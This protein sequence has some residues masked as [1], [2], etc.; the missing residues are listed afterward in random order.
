MAV[1]NPRAYEFATDPQ[2]VAAFRAWLDQQIE[3]DIFTIEQTETWQA[4]LGSMAIGP[5]T[6]HYVGSA[7]K[8]GL[9]NAYLA[10][11]VLAD[12]TQAQAEFIRSM[13]TSPERMSKV[14]LLGTRAF[15]GMKGIT[16]TMA[17]EMSRTLAEGLIDGLGVIEIG[18]LLVERV[19]LAEARALM[20]ARTEIIHAHAEGQLDAFTELGV[21]ELGLQAEWSTAGDDRVCPVCAELEGKVFTV[22]EARG[23]IPQHPNCRCS[24]LPAVAGGSNARSAST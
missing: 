23:K 13:M 6:T 2:K 5:W 14:I 15:E 10:S 11:R 12:I 17:A 4:P 20:V 24:W 1:P 16:S 3:E 8:R 21:Q 7:Y 9:A 18:N 19:G 22:E